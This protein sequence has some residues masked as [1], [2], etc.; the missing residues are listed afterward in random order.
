M[1]N[2]GSSVQCPPKKCSPGYYSLVNNVPPRTR[3]RTVTFG[4]SDT[5]SWE[6][7]FI[8]KQVS[9]E[10]THIPHRP[11]RLW[12]ILSGTH[13]V[14][15]L[16]SLLDFYPGRSYP[17]IC[18]KIMAYK[19]RNRSMIIIASGSTPRVRVSHIFEHCHENLSRFHQPTLTSLFN[20]RLRAI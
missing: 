20:K 18:A 5:N 15:D 13:K 16:C 8:M 2:L 14:L 4:D 10:W 1:K 7:E 17:S 19:K 12:S 3:L 9:F 11:A 6:D